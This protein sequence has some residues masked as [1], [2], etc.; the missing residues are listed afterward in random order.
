MY[1]PDVVSAH[2]HI[3]PSHCPHHTGLLAGFRPGDE[4]TRGALYISISI[5]LSIVNTVIS[6]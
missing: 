1:E 6:F 4:G 3:P 2:W 5:L